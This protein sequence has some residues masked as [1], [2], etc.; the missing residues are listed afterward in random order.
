[1][2]KTLAS[3]QVKRVMREEVR[4]WMWV[5]AVICGYAGLRWVF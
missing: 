2:R 4:S 5:V 1:M 3:P